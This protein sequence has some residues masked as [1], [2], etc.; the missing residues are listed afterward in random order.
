MVR[1]IHG[2]SVR[3]KAAALRSDSRDEGGAGK[4]RDASSDVSGS[5]GRTLGELGHRGLSC[6]AGR[7]CRSARS[8]MRIGWSGRP[9]AADAGVDLGRA[10]RR[11][12][13]DGLVWGEAL[14][15]RDARRRS[16]SLA[17]GAGADCAHVRSW[18][19]TSRLER[20]VGVEGGW[21]GSVKHRSPGGCELGPK[22]ACEEACGGRKQQR[23]RDEGLSWCVGGRGWRR[24]ERTWHCLCMDRDPNVAC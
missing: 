11:S 16:G 21:E 14:M 10:G 13:R 7:S 2:G 15:T 8:A 23:W 1:S 4:G 3:S 5:G 6:G 9:G 20:Y 18:R 17:G 12:D 24:G 22:A 19:Q